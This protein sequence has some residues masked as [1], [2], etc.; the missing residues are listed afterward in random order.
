MRILRFIL[1]PLHF[2]I[3]ILGVLECIRALKFIFFFFKIL[4]SERLLFLKKQ[5]IPAQFLKFAQK[6]IKQN[7]SL[8]MLRIPEKAKRKQ[9]TTTTFFLKK[10]FKLKI[11]TQKEHI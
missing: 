10:V 11:I 6:R 4:W 1:L 5:W 7:A 9:I 2:T 3:R 8:V